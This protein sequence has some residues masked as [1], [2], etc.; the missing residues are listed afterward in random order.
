[1][2]RPNPKPPRE[3][4][5]LSLAMV[6]DLVA[7]RS[8]EIP[9]LA[10]AETR[11]AA[12]EFASHGWP[13]QPGT[14]QVE[15]STAWWGKS[16]ACGL[17]PLSDNGMCG[18]VQDRDR[19]LDIWQRVPY[20][21]LL[22]CGRDID[23]VV[24]GAQHGRRALESLRSS[25]AM[26]PVVRT[27]YGRWAFLV[28][29]HRWRLAELV[30][31]EHVRLLGQGSWVALPPSCHGPSQYRWCVSPA[32]SRWLL[33]ESALVQVA[34]AATALRPSDRRQVENQRS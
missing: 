6:V 31:S 24:V 33:P 18:C 29:T 30:D 32:T 25:G 23:A 28:R 4:P 15:A 19:A 5:V 11:L 21:I 10:V 2:C 3:A 34:L 7:V 8:S 22:A 20:S 16:S 9:G 1:M 26:G 13:I 27:P 17:E 12:V 14:F